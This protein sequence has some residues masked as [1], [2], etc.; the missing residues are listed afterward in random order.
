MCG[1]HYRDWPH[2][3]QGNFQINVSFTLFNLL[4]CPSYSYGSLSGY[5]RV[6]VPE[7]MFDAN[8]GLSFCSSGQTRTV[9]VPN[10]PYNSPNYCNWHHKYDWIVPNGWS[11]APT[12]TGEPFTFLEVFGL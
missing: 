12:T 8:G 2:A 11:V 4:P 5:V 6:V 7:V 10:V 9:S 3:T 1:N